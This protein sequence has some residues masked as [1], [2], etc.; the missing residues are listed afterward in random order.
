MSIKS[1]CVL[2][3]ISPRNRWRLG[4]MDRTWCVEANQCL[5]ARARSLEESRSKNGYSWHVWMSSIL[6]SS[7]IP[8]S[9]LLYNYKYTY[10]YIYICNVNPGLINPYSRLFSWDRYH[11]SIGWNDYWGVPPLINK[12]WFI[13]P[14]LTLYE[15]RCQSVLANHT[16]NDGKK[17][18]SSQE[19]EHFNGGIPHCQSRLPKVFFVVHVRNQWV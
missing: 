19:T 16:T 17:L 11:W 4:H 9:W 1:P 14:G 6:G 12:P 8:Y 5:G 2:F 18:F 3:G 13:N 10:M 15:D 7:H